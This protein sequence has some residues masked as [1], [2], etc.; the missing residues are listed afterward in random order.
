VIL[1]LHTDSRFTNYS[2]DLFSSSRNIHLVGVRYPN[3]KLKF[4]K[5]SEGLRKYV[6]GWSN[7]SKILREIK[8][9]LIVI[10]YLDARWIEVIS[11]V[12][13]DIKIV[14]IFWGG[15][16]YGLPK[17]REGLL[18]PLTRDLIDDSSKT[19]KQ[20]KLKAELGVKSIFSYS[21]IWSLFLEIIRVVKQMGNSENAKITLFERVDY[22]GTF[23]KE[24]YDLLQQFYS[25]KM[26]WMDARF[27]SLQNL[28]GSLDVHPSEGKNILLG[29]SCTVENNHLAAIE[30]M[31]NISLKEGQ[32]VICPLSYG[33]NLG[34]YQKV[35][36][37]EG[38]KV[39]GDGFQPLTDLMPLNKY[40]EMLRS[41]EFAIMFHNR[42]QAFNSILALIYHG[43]KL[44][45]KP[46]NTIFQFLKRKGCFVFSTDELHSTNELE[47]LS[48]NEKK[49]N[50][51]I[52]ILEFSEAKIKESAVCI[53]KIAT[54]RNA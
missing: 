42:Q 51:S 49:I 29:N 11:K 24:D 25:F 15:D 18:D 14:W 13:K 54:K 1:H 20:E 17:I 44:Y 43:A 33:K 28:I 32:N 36:I 2:I 46:Q 48:E 10:H 22:C 41:C 31:K 26:D 35:V 7:C 6:F 39:F 4:T 5:S 3:Q 19:S 16:G 30:L 23:L 40:N 27:I 50:R 52:L 53:E 12:E 45:L 38:G 9:R 8:P 21:F 47:A 37:E 34:N